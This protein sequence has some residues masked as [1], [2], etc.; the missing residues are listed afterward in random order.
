MTTSDGRH[1]HALLGFIR[2]LQQLLRTWQPTHV[3]VAFDAGLPEW[4][5]RLLESYKA[6]RPPM[7]AE[8]REQINYVAE[9]LHA[10]SLAGVSLA[11]EEADDVMASLT[12]RLLERSG[13]ETLLVS[14]DKDLFQLVGSSV[15]LVSP[16]GKPLRTG[17]DEVRAK[18]GV[19][20]SRV[21]FWMALIGD[22]ADNIPGVPGIGPKTAARLLA[23]HENPPALWRELERVQPVSLRNT[24]RAHRE[25]VERNLAL[26]TLR[27]DLPVTQD[28]WRELRREEPCAAQLNDF[29]A[30]YELTSM[31]PAKP[32]DNGQGVLDL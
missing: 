25:L 15:A 9:Y 16:A 30:R 4:R 11:G 2:M 10:F 23:E 3:A 29:F 7:P 14:G 19:H 8:L 5:M 1:T 31:S 22:S 28:P 26:M 13:A 27:R 24:L 12:D 32:P 6:Q 17:I 20:P 21:V 18:T